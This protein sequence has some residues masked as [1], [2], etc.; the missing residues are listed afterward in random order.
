MGRISF[1][2][3]FKC[4]TDVCLDGF[5]YF[6]T[7]LDVSPGHVLNHPLLIAWVHVTIT[8]KPAQ[9]CRYEMSVGTLEILYVLDAVC[10]SKDN[11]IGRTIPL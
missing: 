10:C 6:C 4:P 2:I 1:E 11:N 8:G 5:R 7:L 3:I 9:A